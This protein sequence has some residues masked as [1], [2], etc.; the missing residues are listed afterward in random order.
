MMFR[1]HHWVMAITFALAGHAAA[2][3]F[4]A[5]PDDHGVQ[6][7]AGAT[8]SIAGTNSPFHEI[9]SDTSSSQ[10]VKAEEAQNSDDTEEVEAIEED[11]QPVKTAL[12]EAQEV[13]TPDALPVLPTPTE[14]QKPLEELA[15]QKAQPLEKEAEKPKKKEARKKKKKKKRSRKK[16]TRSGKR[17]ASIEQGGGQRGRQRAVS[18]RASK[19]SYKGRVLSHLG[20]HKR[21]SI[22]KRAG[23]RGTAHVRFSISASGRVTSARLSRSS[24]VSILD[25]E[26]ISMVHRASP[27]PAIPSGLGRGMTFTVPI[28]F[29]LR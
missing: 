15:P 29:R 26:V 17:T 10:E 19:S 23:K 25:R 21:P 22:A 12:L 9:D 24:G 1:I 7:A 5:S 3:G 13:T 4:L 28:N 27:F 6:R 20:R 14:Q 8:V 16:R 2:F 11:I 18:G